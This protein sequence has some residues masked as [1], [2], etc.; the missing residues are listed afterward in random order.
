MKKG[1]RKV[2][3]EYIAGQILVGFKKEVTL[4]QAKDLLTKHSLSL[5]EDTLFKNIRVL[6][7]GVPMGKEHEWCERFASEEIV[8][9]AEVNR[10][11]RLRPL[12]EGR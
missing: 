6:L 10:L 11:N 3:K 12:S 5:L 9:F 1:E 7:V 4:K 8:Q 2:K